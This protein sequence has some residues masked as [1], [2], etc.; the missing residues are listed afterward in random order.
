MMSRPLRDRLLELQQ[1][2]GQVRLAPAA[3]VRARGLRRARR[4]TAGT[5]VACAALVTVAGFGVTAVLGPDGTPDTVATL[6]AGPQGNCRY[7]VDLALPDDPRTVQIEVSAGADRAGQVAG[8]LA[9]RGFAATGH[10][11]IDPDSDTDGTVAVI[12]YGP[13][14]IGAATLVRALVGNGAVMRFYPERDGRTV[15]LAL[16]TEFGRLA[17]TTEVNQ[18]LVEA[19]EPTRPPGC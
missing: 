4:R 8:E 6:P 12:R 17:T 19:G 3:D 10:G 18:A 15:D 5:A 16:G 13:G 7:P 14:A 2:A 1:D 11:L 9:A